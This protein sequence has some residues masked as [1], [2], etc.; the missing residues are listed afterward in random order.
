MI[1]QWQVVNSIWL[2]S[3]LTRPRRRTGPP[4]AEPSS[5][6]SMTPAP[7]GSSL[8]CTGG[9]WG[10]WMRAWGAVTRHAEQN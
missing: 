3:L 10:G 5:R 8:G 1:N 4:P 2:A 9:L 6:G 7:R